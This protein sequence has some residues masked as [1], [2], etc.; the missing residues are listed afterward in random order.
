MVNILAHVIGIE[1]IYMEHLSFRCL[2]CIPILLAI[3]Q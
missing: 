1:I 3:T 2:M